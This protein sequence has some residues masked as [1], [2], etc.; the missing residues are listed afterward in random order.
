MK[1]ICSGLL[2]LSVF[3]TFAGDKEPFIDKGT[4]TVGIAY[5]F[6]NVIGEKDPR[7]SIGSVIVTADRQL[8]K[9]FNIG[10]QYNFNYTDGGPRTRML[11]NNISYQSVAKSFSH[12][13]SFNSE[14]CFVNRG[15]VC[16]GSGLGMAIGAQRT[17]V[18]YNYTQNIVLRDNNYTVFE[19]AF[20]LRIVDVQVKLKD[21]LS[22]TGCLGYGYDGL[23]TAGVQYTFRRK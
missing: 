18:N 3:T 17:Y 13:V 1:Y 10:L 20:M 23:V 7:V 19:L 14:Y 9:R 5:G 16:L 21:N 4:H 2:L 12:R 8:S 11:T 15:K 6:P 22:V